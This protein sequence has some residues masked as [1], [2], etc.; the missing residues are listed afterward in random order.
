MIFVASNYV[1]LSAKFLSG[2]L[3]LLS[4]NCTKIGTN[5]EKKGSTLK[6][7]EI[8]NHRLVDRTKNSNFDT[9]F[10]KIDRKLT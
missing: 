6:S 8:T 10:L 2:T 4:A 5:L 3:C 1:K 7:D 9:W